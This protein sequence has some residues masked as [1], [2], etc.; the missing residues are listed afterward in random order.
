[1]RLLLIQTCTPNF[2]LY[3]VTYTRCSIDTINSPDDGHMA[4][5]NM[6]RIEINIHEK[7]LCINLVIYKNYT[8]MHGQQNIKHSVTLHYASVTSFPHAA[9]LQLCNVSFWTNRKNRAYGLEI[10]VLICSKKCL[11]I[12]KFLQYLDKYNGILSLQC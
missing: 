4:A 10:K 6:Y 3:R 12:F 1:M 2:H 7:E 9:Y 11:H 5:R 8:E